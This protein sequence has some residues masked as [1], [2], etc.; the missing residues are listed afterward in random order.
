MGYIIDD[1]NTVEMILG[2]IKR[3]W[4]NKNLKGQ[5]PMLILGQ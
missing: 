4:Q 5:S 1:N 3:K 2:G